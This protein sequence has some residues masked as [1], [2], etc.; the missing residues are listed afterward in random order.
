MSKIIA[1]ISEYNPFH[2]GHKYQI[3]KIKEQEP[4]ST[5]LAIMS[6][7][8]VQRGEFAIL[9]KYTRAK[10]AVM[11]GV[12][13][14]FELPYPYSG[15]TAEIFAYGGVNLASNLGADILY[16]GTESESLDLLIEMAKVIDSDEYE[17]AFSSIKDEVLSFPQAREKALS[18]LGYKI[19]QSSNDILAIEYIR[20]INKN[21]QHM[22]YRNIKRIGADYNDV[23][24]SHFMSATGIRREFYEKNELLSLPQEAKEIFVEASD[25]GLV[26]RCNADCEL[27]YKYVLLSQPQ[28]LENTFDT[29]YGL[30]YFLWNRA[31]ESCDG[32]S[33]IEKLSSKQFTTARL[34]RATLYSIFN[35]KKPFL[36]KK[37]FTVLLGCNEKG[38]KII[39]TAKSNKNIVVL[40]K[41]A[42]SKKL[43]K[44]QKRIYNILMR[45]DEIYQ[46]LLVSAKSPKE[47]YNKIP[48]IK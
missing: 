32:E 20:Q 8:I 3:D 16:F 42:D 5:I 17:K 41:H 9:D 43:N 24:V 31:K 1:I 10:M 7:N 6:G 2:N 14:V 4:D 34:K 27:L 25:K 47:A 44:F 37:N 40:T 22:E 23:E 29:P 13:A 19:P 48:F 30:G 39:K 26:K 21:A 45:V 35:V 46:T 12:D 36:L 18:L 11:C 38:K 28:S 33:F 15:S